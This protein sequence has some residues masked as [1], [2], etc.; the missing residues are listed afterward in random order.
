MCVI[1]VRRDWQTPLFDSIFA[2]AGTYPMHD[3]HIVHHVDASW[4]QAWTGGDRVRFFKLNGSILEITAAP[5]PDPYTG[6]T[7]VGRVTFQKWEA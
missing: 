1:V 5:T 2:Y 4:N 6:R 7:V 3:N